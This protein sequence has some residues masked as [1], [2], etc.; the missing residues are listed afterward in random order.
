MNFLAVAYFK[1][2]IFLILDL[3]VLDTF[4][5]ATILRDLKFKFPV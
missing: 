5:L 3:G 1:I 2:L 4:V